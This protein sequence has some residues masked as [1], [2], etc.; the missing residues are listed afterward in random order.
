MFKQKTDIIE[1]FLIGVF[2]TKRHKTHKEF[3]TTD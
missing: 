2:A 3:V 1:I